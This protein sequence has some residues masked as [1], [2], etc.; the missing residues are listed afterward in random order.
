MNIS[1]IRLG[2]ANNS[3]STHS[4][5]LV[6]NNTHHDRDWYDNQFGWEN[7]TLSSKEAKANYFAMQIYYALRKTL[8]PVGIA[9]VAKEITGIDFSPELFYDAENHDAYIDH[10]SVMDLPVN[11]GDQFN[12]KFAKDFFSF[13]SQENILILG[14]NDNSDGHPLRGEGKNV[15]ILST[16]TSYKFVAKWDEL[17][18]WVLF[19]KKTGAKVRFTFQ[20]LDKKIEKSSKPELVDL[21]ITNYCDLNCPYCYQNSSSNG[22]HATDINYILWK[23]E[24]LGVLEIAIGGGEPTTHP[25]FLSILKEIHDYNMV[26]NFTT[27]SLKW[28]EDDKFRESVFQYSRSFAYSVTTLNQIKNWYQLIE[29]YHINNWDSIRSSVQYVIGSN[30]EDELKK[31]MEFCGKHFISLTLLGFK[32]NGRGSQFTPFDN[33][34]WLSI[35]KENKYIRLGIDTLLAKQYENELEKFNINPVLY[36][37]EEGKFSMYI[38]AVDKKIGRSSYCDEYFSFDHWRNLDVEIMNHYEEW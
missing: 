4:I 20:D 2:F 28:L 9:S 25:E 8:D 27:R 31:I 15:D 16:D 36:G 35:A 7:F 1:N 6:N 38:D 22:N 5:I 33:S 23:L 26:A 19:N 30:T 18:Y 21:K 12:A 17:G 10:Q 29:K 24:S 3:S 14:G 32:T 34:N 37:T 11:V 13:L